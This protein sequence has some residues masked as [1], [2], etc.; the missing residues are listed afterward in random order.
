MAAT[1]ASQA[2]GP[3]SVV[4]LLTAFNN[5]SNPQMTVLLTVSVDYLFG[6]VFEMSTKGHFVCSCEQLYLSFENTH[7]V[8]RSQLRVIHNA[9]AFPFRFKCRRWLR[10]LLPDSLPLV[11]LHQHSFYYHGLT[12]ILAW[13]INCI[14]CLVWGDISY[15]FHNFNDATEWDKYFSTPYNECNYLSML[16]LK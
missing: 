6:S 11:V 13:I 1:V 10:C 15:P 3:L 2:P 4:F 9:I 12:L 5:L 14:R 16:I 8:F 7:H